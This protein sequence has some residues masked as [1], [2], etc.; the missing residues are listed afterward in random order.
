MNRGD[1]C[2]EYQRLEKT[3]RRSLSQE[4]ATPPPHDDDETAAHAR[5]ARHTDSDDE[6]AA[7]ARSARHTDSDDETAAH[8]RSA[9]HTDSDDETRSPLRCDRTP[10]VQSGSIAGSSGNKSNDTAHGHIDHVH[11]SASSESRGNKERQE[12]LVRAI[13]AWGNQH[14]VEQDA[15]DALLKILLKKRTVK[16]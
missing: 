2:R 8:A 16:R 15:V 5:S 1:K 11:V 3:A 6:T 14:D 4:H 9:R 10:A 7:H 12:S 13:V